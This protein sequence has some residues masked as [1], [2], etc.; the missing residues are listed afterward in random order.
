V[1]DQFADQ[2]L[3]QRTIEH[4]G[5]PVPLVHVV[6]GEDGGVFVAEGEGAIGLALEVEARRRSG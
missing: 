4:D 3:R 2:G 5:V 6:A 1:V